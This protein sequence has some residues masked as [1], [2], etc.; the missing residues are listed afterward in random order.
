[1]ALSPIVT[2]TTD[3][4][5]ADSYVGILKGVILGICPGARLVD[6]SHLVPPQDIAAGALLLRQ[7]APYFSTDTIHLRWWI[8]GSAANWRS[9]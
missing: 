7:A 5:L 8:P 4:G 6:L 9:P 3:F 1:M 2:L